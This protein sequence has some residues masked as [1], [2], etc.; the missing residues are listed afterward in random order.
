MYSLRWHY[1]VKDIAGA[2]C[3]I[4]LKKTKKK[5]KRQKRRQS[6]V[7]GR[8]SRSPNHRRTTTENYSLQLATERRQRRC[9]P[10]RRRQAVPC[11][12]RCH[13]EGTVAERWTSGGRYHRHGCVECWRLMS[14]SV[15]VDCSDDPTI[16]LVFHFRPCCNVTWVGLGHVW[17]NVWFFMAILELMKWSI[18]T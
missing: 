16:S 10:D 12:C 18:N 1:H 15:A 4:K 13:W 5:Q 7:A 17:S 14:I 9:I 2:P 6:V 11:T 3:K 8:Q